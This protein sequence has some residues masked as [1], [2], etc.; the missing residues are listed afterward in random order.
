MNPPINKS[1]IVQ[2]A[3]KSGSSFHGQ[4]KK[5]HPYMRDNFKVTD[6]IQK[7]FER[8]SKRHTI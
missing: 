7:T 2:G 4:L 3:A 1:N 6:E 8:I 5:V